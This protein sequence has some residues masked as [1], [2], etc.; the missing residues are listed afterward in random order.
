MNSYEYAKSLEGVYPN[1]LIG[2]Y[3]SLMNVP[4]GEDTTY[5][6]GDLAIYN[7]KNGITSEQ[8]N[9]AFLKALKAT[10]ME[11]VVEL[12]KSGIMRKG[13]YSLKILMCKNLGIQIPE[14]IQRSIENSEN[15]E[16]CSNMSNK[17]KVEFINSVESS[18]DMAE[19]VAPKD[20]RLYDELI[21]ERTYHSEQRANKSIDIQKKCKEIGV[22]IP[23]I[24]AKQLKDIVLDNEVYNEFSIVQFRLNSEKNIEA[25]VRGKG[26]NRWFKVQGEK[27]NPYV[28]TQVPYPQNYYF[29]KEECGR[30]QYY[31]QKLEASENNKQISKECSQKPNGQINKIIR[32]VEPMEL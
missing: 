24:M 13:D 16:K 29:K 23:E 8:A 28:V 21:N 22:E 12:Q 32:T 9:A 11:T 7:I 5:W 18:L 27:N 1:D 3:E 14:H 30:F 2:T 26:M 25:N 19:Q 31:R 6:F 20:I 15:L 4:Y 17:E 10:G